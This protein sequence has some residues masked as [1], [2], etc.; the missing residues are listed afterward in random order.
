VEEEKG[1]DG[2]T[3]RY[4][5]DLAGQVVSVIRPNWKETAYEYDPCGR[6]SKVIYNLDGNERERKEETYEYRRDGALISAICSVWKLA[7]HLAV[8]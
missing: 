7:G 6:V 8:A 4:Y 5:R 1:F 2:L 3:R